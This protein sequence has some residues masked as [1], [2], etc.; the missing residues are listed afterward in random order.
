[1]PKGELTRG[2]ATSVFVAAAAAMLASAACISESRCQAR[3]SSLQ[4]TAMVAIFFA[5]F[6]DARV[7]GGELRQAL[8]SLRG[9][10]S[11]TH[12]SHAGP[13]LEMC[14]CRT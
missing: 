8:G 10:V 6:R 14:P 3:V 13:C 2:L 4:E 7:G 12:R 1:M 11:L 5:A 9:L